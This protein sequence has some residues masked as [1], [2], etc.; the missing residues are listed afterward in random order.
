M[1][2]EETGCRARFLIRDR[3]GKY[4][5]LF[6]DVLADAR[7]EILL[8]GV[9][10][11]RMNSIMERW[12]QTC[13]RELLDR[14]L[15]WNQRHLLHALCEFEAFYNQHRP[16][17][18]ISNGRPLNPLPPPIT[19]HGSPPDRPPRCTPGRPSVPSPLHDALTREASRRVGLGSPTGE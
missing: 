19:D 14:T 11:P 5:K 12:M 6:D 15:I 10:M 9:R 7:I 13:Q 4:P 8:T 18:G 3:D 2:L 1:D 17:Q 16:H